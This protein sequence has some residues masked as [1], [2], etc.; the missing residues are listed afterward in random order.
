MVSQSKPGGSLH[1]GFRLGKLGFGLAAS[2]LGHRVQRLFLDPAQRDDQRKRMEI[3]AARL[4]RQELQSLRGP[5]MKLGQTLS[6]QSHLL[7]QEVV[8]E[9][10][11]LQ[12]RAPPMHPTLAR[13]QFKG[14]LGKF[15]EEIL[16]EFAPEPL[17]AASLGQVHRAVTKSGKVVAVKIQY[18]AIRLAIENDFRILRSISLPA[19]LGKFASE[20]MIS[21]L[22][23]GILKETDYLNEGR[24]I[25]FFSKKLK[26]L[27]YV[28]VPVVFWE[29]TTDRV[30]T[31]SYVSGRPLT[32]FFAAR[33]TSTELRNRIGARLLALF[34]FQLRRIHAIH[35][36]PHPGNYLV[37]D[38]GTIGLVDFGCV[39]KF[40]PEFV[41]LIAS[42]ENRAWTHSKTHMHRMAELIW[43]RKA[44]SSSRRWQKAL[45]NSIDL[46][47]SIFNRSDHALVDFGDS[48]IFKRILQVWG[49]SL[50]GNA[51]NPEYVFYGRAELGLFNVLHQLRAKIDPAGILVKLEDPEPSQTDHPPTSG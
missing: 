19:R 43:G 17:A 47:E 15:P 8:D 34:G 27:A 3:K 32:D 11:N 40:S 28:E 45:R 41:E 2:Y 50:S 29:M 35:A 31:M 26:P 36:D 25:E 37:G 33:K 24:N 16:R 48:R 23:Q 9:L 14:A 18:P 44:V 30:L 7:P 38:G 6:M 10:A 21:E 20:A 13:A 46:Y 42:F 12:M 4:V 49:E 39:K 51:V 1:R 5:V 22:E